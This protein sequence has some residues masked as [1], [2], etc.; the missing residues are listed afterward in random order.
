MAKYHVQTVLDGQLAPG[1]ALQEFAIDDG[2]FALK[3]ARMEYDVIAHDYP[4]CYTVVIQGW[5]HDPVDGEPV[6]LIYNRVE[7]TEPT[8]IGTMLE[9]FG[10]EED[11][12]E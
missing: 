8:V 2:E 10:D 3:C 12:P 6:L 1:A 4:L 5:D 11:N 7:Y 9:S